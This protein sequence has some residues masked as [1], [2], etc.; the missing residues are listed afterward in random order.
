LRTRQARDALVVQWLG[1]PGYII[2]QLRHVE[3]IRQVDD[4]Q[5]VCAVALVRAAELYDETRNVS[6][7]SY[8]RRA[9]VNALFGAT[10]DNAVAHV[11]RKRA[12]AGFKLPP[13]VTLDEA[14]VVP[15]RDA[16]EGRHERAAR[17]VARVL[18]VLD[19]DEALLLHRRF[20]LRWTLSKIG[21]RM[22]VTHETARQHLKKLV[23]QIPARLAEAARQQAQ[24]TV[25]GSQVV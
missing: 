11:P 14:L 15:A 3:D 4:P 24:A 1:L 5:G 6:F 19:G 12:Q 23:E 9:L 17:E 16:A 13:T 22:G 18:S 21:E 8:A 25:N 20:I 10:A 2:K 7:Y